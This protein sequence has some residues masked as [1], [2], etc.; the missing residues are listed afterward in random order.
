MGGGVSG[1]RGS[2]HCTVREPGPGRGVG[3]PGAE[4]K[5]HCQFTPTVSKQPRV[6]RWAS[7]ATTLSAKAQGQC[8]CQSCDPLSQNW[9]ASKAQHLPRH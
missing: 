4:G 5:G 7:V 8:V 1:H 9:M 6:N 2:Q 3:K